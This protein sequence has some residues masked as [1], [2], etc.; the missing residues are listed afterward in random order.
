MRRVLV[1]TKESAVAQTLLNKR[2]V[3]NFRRQ[4]PV[5]STRFD[6]GRRRRKKKFRHRLLFGE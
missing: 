6:G 1:P 4:R 3:L 5:E 2:V